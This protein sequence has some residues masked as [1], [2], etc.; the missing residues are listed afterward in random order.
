[1][2]D[3]SAHRVTVT[4]STPPDAGPA[5]VMLA[6]EVDMTAVPDLATAIDR[7]RSLAPKTVVIDLRAVTFACATLV[8]FIVRLRQASPAADVLVC[9]PCPMTRRVLEL[10][11]MNLITTIVECLPGN[12]GDHL[13]TGQHR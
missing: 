4:T 11:G 2:K 1:M 13:T 5:C 8:T 6:G 7:L 3:P 12:C 9:R 10:T